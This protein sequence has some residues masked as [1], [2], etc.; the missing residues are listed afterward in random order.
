MMGEAD[1][2]PSQTEVGSRAPTLRPP[3][4]KRFRGWA[5][6]ALLVALGGAAGAIFAARSIAASDTAK[7][8]A[9]F[10]QSSG[11]VASTLQLAIQREQD[12]VVTGAGFFLGDPDASNTQFREWSTSVQAL[13][14]FPEL[15]NWGEIALVPASQL[16]AFAA[17]F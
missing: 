1:W 14:R 6:V 9:A 8:R 2:A 16:D 17:R 7:S 15:L 3:R 13:Q 4:W 12:L 10:K 11:Q 5:V